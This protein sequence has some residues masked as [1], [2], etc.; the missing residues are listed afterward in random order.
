MNIHELA[1]MVNL[2]TY[3]NL[4]KRQLIS[5]DNSYQEITH[6]NQNSSENYN[7]DK[8]TFPNNS[9]DN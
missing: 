8:R 5:S 6:I 9:S 1:M 3:I 4:K 2:G 7:L